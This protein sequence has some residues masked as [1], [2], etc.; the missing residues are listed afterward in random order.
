M[1]C[2]NSDSDSDS[3]SDSNSNSN[4]HNRGSY[5][6]PELRAQVFSRSFGINNNNKDIIITIAI[7]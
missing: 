6:L 3:D 7:I 2:R 4:E 1:A 5:H